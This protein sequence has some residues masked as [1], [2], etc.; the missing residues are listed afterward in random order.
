MKVDQMLRVGSGQGCRSIFYTEMMRKVYLQSFFGSVF[1]IDFL[2]NKF[3][4]YKP[5]VYLKKA[6]I[7]QAKTWVTRSNK[8][9]EVGRGRPPGPLFLE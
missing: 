2:D 5:N 9:R 6:D 8:A 4:R 7:D 1:V 3:N